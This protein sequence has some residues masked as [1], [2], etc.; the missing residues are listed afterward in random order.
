M[1]NNLIQN[2]ND[3]NQYLSMVN[4][5]IS[6]LNKAK[7]SPSS[8]KNQSSSLP[9]FLYEFFVF[10][11]YLPSE[12]LKLIKQ[13]ILAFRLLDFPSLTLEG[14]INIQ[15]QSIIFN[16]G[17]S[18][19]FEMDLSELKDNL[20]NQPMYIMFLDLNHGNIKIIGNCRLNISLFAYDSF[21]N[22]GHGQIPEPRRNILQLFDNTMEKCGEFEMSLIIRREYY[23][24]D[25]NIETNETNK[26]VLIK[27]AKKQRQILTKDKIANLMYKGKEKPKEPKEIFY[28]NNQISSSKYIKPQY[29][30]NI[31]IEKNDTAFNAHPINKE[32]IIKPKNQEEKKSPEKMSGNKKIKK[33]KVKKVN[34]QTETDLIPGVD[35]PINQ[36]DYH[37]K[38]VKKKKV[39][40]NYDYNKMN[41]IYQNNQALINSMYNKYQSDSKYN[42]PEYELRPNYQDNNY[43][44]PN[45]NNN[46]NINYEIQNNQM[47]Q[48]NNNNKQDSQNKNTYLNFLT[49]LKNQVNYYTNN[50]IK[51]KKELE[52]IK[53]ER[54]LLPI[55]ENNNLEID[56][57]GNL[58]RN[59]SDNEN[60]NINIEEN[61]NINDQDKNIKKSEN[62]EIQE[63]SEEKENKP[64]IQNEENSNNDDNQINNNVNDNINNVNDNDN[65]NATKINE[66]KKIEIINEEIKEEEEYDDFEKMVE[67]DKS[68]N[69]KNQNEL[70]DN[71]FNNYNI[72]LEKKEQEDIQEN[73]NNNDLDNN[74]N[75]LDTNNNIPS[76][77]EIKES[78]SL[79]KKNTN[80]ENQAYSGEINE[81]IDE[82][83]ISNKKQFRTSNNE[84]INSKSDNKGIISSSTENIE[85]LLK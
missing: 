7:I 64:E 47:N 53:E 72:D 18:S 40:K 45:Y 80:N 39:K 43:N 71:K 73:V 6:Q 78:S 61:N 8:L 14:N 58:E 9:I 83:L 37:K 42:F 66:N 26:T 54:N 4:Y 59:K 63:S 34:A 82:N 77:N 27:K 62:L 17:K 85:N 55:Q 57:E 75:N 2:Q 38:N 36:V 3:N 23:K 41:N 28:D 84:E 22:Y 67:S 5:L 32:I 10:E 19:F 29:V 35:V 20:L 24:F 31:I 50:L 69:K 33:E 13:P 68:A 70:L 81:E 25:K 30:N 1:D 44:N 76:E 48:L 51:G 15:K 21:L 12:L 56:K 16:Q 52:K 46:K 60:N 11:L 49:D 79:A 65:K 74:N